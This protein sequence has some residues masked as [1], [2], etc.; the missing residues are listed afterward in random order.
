M[1]FI[2]IIV[3]TIIFY[4]LTVVIIRLLG[5]REVGEISVFDLVVLLII[6]D[7][8]TIAITKEWVAVL[9]S[10]VSL[11]TLLGLQKL[12]AFIALKYPKV[13]KVID[14][15]PSIIIYN[16][17]V[18]LEEMKKQAYTIDDL[19]TQAR[20]KGVM[21]L[22]EV[23]LAILESSGDLS[24]YKIDE[25]NKIIL[26]IIVSGILVGDNIKMLKLKLS[27]IDSYLKKNDLKLEEINYLSSDGKEF[28]TLNII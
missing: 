17:E 22:S 21:D 7:V 13:R 8:S 28:Y 12:F 11:L 3:K 24:I 23:K 26:P 9:Y 10:G 15:S 1:E 18:N 2:N 20:G 5:K 16:G 19:I 14:Y 4:I 27:E 25:Y 6:A